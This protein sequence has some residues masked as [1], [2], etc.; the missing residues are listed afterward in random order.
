MTP[1]PD[2]SQER[3]EQILNAAEKV[4]SERG[5]SGARMDDIV[6]EAGLSKGALYWYY[7]SKDAIILALLDRVFARELKAA[8]R[9]VE[10]PGPAGERLKIFM[11]LTLEEIARLGRLLPLGY[12]FL[13]L[14][15]RRKPVRLWVA[16]Y[17][18]GYR[19]LLIQILQQG[20]ESGEFIELNVE[21]A[22]MHIIALGEGLA[23]L[24]FIA[25]DMVDI[26]RLGDAPMEALLNGFRARTTQPAQAR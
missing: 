17:Y 13:A 5:F 18:R 24:R 20:V 1:R 25:P 21:Q 9:L 7:K 14:A 22:A 11:K 3:Q 8:E 16:G 2:V 15:S 10:A 12:E 4:F 26:K 19:D 23:L 6:E